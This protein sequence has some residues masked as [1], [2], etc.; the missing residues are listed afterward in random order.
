MKAVLQRVTKASV[1]VEGQ[2]IGHIDA[3]LLVLVG[4]A[5]GDT[6]EDGAW[7]ARKIAELRVFEDAA[8]KMNL[9]LEDTGGAVLLVSQFTLLADCKKG[10]RPGFDAAA[11]PDEALKLCQ[12]L[13]QQLRSRGLAVQTGRFGADMKV[14]LLNDGPVTLLL[15]S[16]N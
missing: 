11:L 13:E 7:M 10:R 5:K 1:S 14:E 12:A 4:V 2:Q 9:S 6:D 3:G 8:G 15:D 16:R